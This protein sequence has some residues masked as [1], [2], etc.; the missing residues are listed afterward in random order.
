M[1]EM[2][3]FS[4]SRGASA[5]KSDL[6]HMHVVVQDMLSQEAKSKVKPPALPN[7]WD[8]VDAG[9]LME[10]Q[11]ELSGVVLLE[12]QLPSGEVVNLVSSHEVVNRE[13][14]MDE[15]EDDGE[16]ENGFK[17]AETSI[18][19]LAAI[20]KP[21][22]HLPLFFE[23]VGDRYGY[24]IL[25]IHVGLGMA[26]FMSDHSGHPA[27]LYHA[28]MSHKDA[29]EGKDSVVP[30]ETSEDAPDS[31]CSPEF[32]TLDARLQDKFVDFLSEKHVDAVVVETLFD[33]VIAEGHAKYVNFLEQLDVWLK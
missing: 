22:T 10:G 33:L 27:L 25:R 7:G 14:D 18:L 17:H 4:G 16:Q 11:V 6:D 12:K 1:R 2:R 3:A 24:E 19:F 20:D 13:D 5:G 29:R 8:R 26:G 30:G 32:D 21:G 9:S 28:Y 23:C 15:D 31:A